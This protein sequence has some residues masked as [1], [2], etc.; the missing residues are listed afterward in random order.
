MSSDEQ[1]NEQKQNQIVDHPYLQHAY[2][3]R[4]RTLSDIIRYER[5]FINLNYDSDTTSFNS[6]YK[7][8]RAR[9]LECLVCTPWATDRADSRLFDLPDDIAVLD[10]LDSLCLA[11][12]RAIPESIKYLKGLTELTV[13]RSP[14]T[15]AMPP[16]GCLKSLTSLEKLVLSDCGGVFSQ[17]MD[18]PNIKELAVYSQGE[19]PAIYRDVVTTLTNNLH[20]STATAAPPVQNTTT[21]S[22]TPRLCNF[23]NSLESFELE[24]NTSDEIAVDVVVLLLQ[25]FPNLKTIKLLNP[26]AYMLERRGRDKSLFVGILTNRLLRLKEERP[27]IFPLRLERLYVSS[28]LRSIGALKN[29][30]KLLDILEN[31]SISRAPPT[32]P[33]TRAPPTKPPVEDS[34]EYEML[35]SMLISTLNKRRARVDRAIR[36]K[37]K[38]P[39][40]IWT[41]VIA[42]VYRCRCFSHFD[43]GNII[44]DPRNRKVAKEWEASLVYAV[45]RDGLV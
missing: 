30:M 28:G 24:Y 12:Y 40:P 39:M 26:Q 10:Q 20:A 5:F 41:N 43:A 13:V 31:L 25:I 45:L 2:P 21:G 16:A 8:G 4:P 37:A 19:S 38:L 11:Y 9:R 27:E 32:K 29:T 35:S 18:L 1:Q 42:R 36:D 6:Y 3:D 17:F 22:T 15:F 44:F 34:Q 33:R 7:S 14:D 23:A